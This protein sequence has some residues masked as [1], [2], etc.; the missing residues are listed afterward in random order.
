MWRV[1]VIVIII[2]IALCLYSVINLKTIKTGQGESSEITY[3]QIVEL[4]PQFIYIAGK[5]ASGKTTLSNKLADDGYHILHVDEIIREGFGGVYPTKIWGSKDESMFE[6]ITKLIVFELDKLKDQKVVLEGIIGTSVLQSV[7]K[8][9]KPD[10]FLFVQHRTKDSYMKAIKQ[11]A[12][13]DIESDRSGNALGAFWDEPGANEAIEDYKQN[14]PDGKLFNKYIENDVDYHL[15]NLVERREAFF[16]DYDYRIYYT[17]LIGGK[18]L[19]SVLAHV[20]GPAGVGK[21]ALAEELFKKY[22]DVKFVDLDTI[23]EPNDSVRDVLNKINQFSEN[24]IL[25]GYNE[26]KSGKWIPIPARNFYFMSDDPKEII[27]RRTTR[28]SK[29]NNKQPSAKEIIQWMDEIEKDEKLYKSKGYVIMPN[30]R[31]RIP[32]D[33][34]INMLKVKEKLTKLTYVPTIIHISGAPG[35][36][37]STLAKKLEVISDKAIIVDTDE[38]FYDQ[39][40]EIYRKHPELYKKFAIKDDKK[41]W[42]IVWGPSYI[43]RWEELIMKAAKEKKHFIALGIT[44]DLNILADYHYMIDLDPIENYRRRNI[45]EIRK[46]CKNQ[47]DIEELLQ[48]KDVAEALYTIFMKHDHHGAVVGLPSKEIKGVEEDKKELTKVGY[49]LLSSE[50]IEKEVLK[51]MS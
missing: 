34:Q 13:K 40:R 26:T 32:I 22:K 2:I 45:R 36:G 37:K 41:F 33:W 8:E 46:I 47:T 25:V 39:I 9:H 50:K 10:L 27:K 29:I 44:A 4:D 20:A 35:S 1:I 6:K 16:K 28:F 51:I 30:D 43:K 12:I 24:T 5:G 23:I 11:R 18:E 49:K 14:G 42:D 19:I 7:V 17:D 31:I 38:V 15:S 3:E 21:T 48:T